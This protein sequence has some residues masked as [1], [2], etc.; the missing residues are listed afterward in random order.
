MLKL[1]RIKKFSFFIKINQNILVCI[2]HKLAGIRRLFRHI[3]LAVYELYKR[4]I[5]LSPHLSVILTKSRRNMNDTGTVCH[6]DIVVTCYIMPF[7]MLLC[8]RFSRTGK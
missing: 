1:R 5:I 4:Q 8:R 7:L 3:S 2:L 6:C